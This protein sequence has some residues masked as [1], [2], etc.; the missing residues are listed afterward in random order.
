[1]HRARA[2]ALIFLTLT[3]ASIIGGLVFGAVT[4]GEEAFAG[5][6][7][8][9]GIASFFLVAAYVSLWASRRAR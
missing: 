8:F 7:L 3:F 1:M 4:T 9:L 6:W 5:G 2:L